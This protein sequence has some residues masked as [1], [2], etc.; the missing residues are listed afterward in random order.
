[1]LET[2]KSGVRASKKKEMKREGTSNARKPTATILSTK[3]ARM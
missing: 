2:K 1:M 3:E